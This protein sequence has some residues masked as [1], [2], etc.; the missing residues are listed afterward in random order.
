M[1]LGSS[2]R[3]GSVAGHQGHRES[4]APGVV[5]LAPEVPDPLE[6]ER[7]STATVLSTPMASPVSL[8]K[9]LPESP[10]MP[11]VIV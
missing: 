5:E 4:L 7:G 3:N 6:S 2:G 8:R 10:G 9:P 11:G 1:A